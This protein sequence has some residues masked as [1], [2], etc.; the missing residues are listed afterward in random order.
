[1]APT[2][3]PAQVNSFTILA[4]NRSQRTPRRSSVREKNPETWEDTGV[5]DVSTRASFHLSSFPSLA[6]EQ[7]Q[8]ALHTTQ[9][10]G[11]S[12]RPI[13]STFPR[14]RF[15]FCPNLRLP[16]KSLFPESGWLFE[17][18]QSSARLRWGGGRVGG[19]KAPRALPQPQQMLAVSPPL[20]AFLSVEANR[21][22]A[23]NSEGNLGELASCREL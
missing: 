7:K 4:V 23:R 17:L 20:K 5:R 9:R 21:S 10:S 16:G 6:A 11:H 12:W 19:E 15:I 3:K 22:L 2:A 18:T 8:A 13:K 14:A 1:M